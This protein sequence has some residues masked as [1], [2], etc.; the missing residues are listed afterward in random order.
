MLKVVC[1]RALCPHGVCMCIASVVV[2][3][4]HQPGQDIPGDTVWA[5]DAPPTPRPL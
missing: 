1:N 2:R 3:H 4:G 5:T